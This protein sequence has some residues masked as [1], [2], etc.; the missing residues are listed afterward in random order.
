MKI[1][2]GTWASLISGC[3]KHG[4]H[5]LAEDYF[6]MMIECGVEPTPY[7]WTALVQA[8]ARG[9][10]TDSALEQ[11]DILKRTGVQPTSMMFTT[12]LHCMIDAD[13]PDEANKLWLR[14][15]WEDF[16]LTLDC[17][18]TILK[19]CIKT[20]QLFFVFILKISTYVS[21]L[22]LTYYLP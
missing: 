9:R 5:K 8:K 3:S 14:M 16:K 10:G 17:F 1:E 13:K 19:L 4:R 15:H 18:N 22:F 21:L 2:S 7:S 20:G 12:I 11:I 6:D